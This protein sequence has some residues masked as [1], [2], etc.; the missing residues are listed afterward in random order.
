MKI[1]H[2]ITGLNDGGAEGVLCRL[3]T[4]DTHNGHVVVSLMGDGKYGPL[5]RAAGVEVHCLGMPRGRFTVRALWRLWQLLRTLPTDVVQTWMYHADLVGGIVARLAGIR[6]I[7][8]GIRH[9]TLDSN[10]SAQSTIFVARL[11]ALLS[12][13]VPRVIVSCAEESVRVHRELGYAERKFLVIPNGY[14]L[15]HF[16]PDSGARIRLRT[17]WGINDDTPLIGMVARYDSQKDHANLVAALTHLRD[18]GTNFE[19]VLVGTGIDS[20]NTTLGDAINAAGLS[21]QIRLL[22]RRADVPAIMNAL[23]LHVLSSSFGEA[24][25]N[26]LAEA[27]ACGTPCVTTDVGDAAMIV[28]DTGWVVPPGN[29]AALAG[30]LVNALNEWKRSTVWQARCR[31]ARE[32]V[33]QHFA[34]DRMVKSYHA[35]WRLAKYGLPL[36]TKEHESL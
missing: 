11:C 12:G 3:C 22:G 17:E 19:C 1:T 14:D 7:C 34:I 26:V 33:A 15:I 27:M 21:T 28:G 35:V 5:L 31:A 24:F 18:I 4:H 36:E 32:H 16:E 6:A 13:C 9:T 8:W 10:D 30:A 25:P 20:E 23:D 29:S 2:I